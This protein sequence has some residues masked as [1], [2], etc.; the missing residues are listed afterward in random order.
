MLK[1]SEQSAAVSALMAELISQYLDPD[2]IRV[3]NGAIPEST[4]VSLKP[5]LFGKLDAERN[6]SAA[7]RAPV[8][9]Q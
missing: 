2:V 5:S 8:G 7:A 1:P 9:P 6:T 4:K 3:V